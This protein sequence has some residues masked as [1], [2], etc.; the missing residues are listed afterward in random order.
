MSFVKQIVI[1]AVVIVLVVGGWYAYQ[2]RSALFGTPSTIAA[3]TP[4]S[5]PAAAK[6]GGP[7]G[8]SL[9]PVPV[10]AAPVDIATTSDQLSAIGTLAA[11]QEV[12]LF[13]Q[14][15]GIVT[16][17]TFKPGSH[18]TAGQTLVTLDAKDQQVAVDRA[19]VALDDAKTALDRAQRLSKTSNI[20]EVDLQTAQ[21]NER[22]AEIDARAAQ[23]DLDKL[24]IK[25][26]FDGTIGLT[27][28]SVGDLITSTTAIAT[29]DDM[30][31]LTL[32]FQSPERFAGRIAVG[33]ALKA[34]AE[35]LPGVNLAGKIV[36][37][38]SRIDAATRTLKLQAS[39]TNENGKLK[40]GMAISVVMDFPGQP[41]PLVPSLS[42]QYDRKG[43]FVWKVAGDVV[44][45]V[46][47][48][49][50]DRT[51]RAVSVMADLKKGDQVVTEGV[52]SLREGSKIARLDEAPAAATPAAPATP[53]PAAVA[54]AAASDAA[55]A[56]V[57]PAGA[58]AAPTRTD[59]PS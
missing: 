18:V 19:T 26:P 12:T 28:L 56:A 46:A 35:S 7:G 22:K 31:V 30:S 51:G 32:D 43:A 20:T 16:S 58:N 14:V 21:N 41:E 3:A 55:P 49:V 48:T 11:A 15:T 24:T 10:V 25:A 23:L 34:T 6:P 33:D 2:H 13:P 27:N 1:S 59:Q 45:R 44:N 42:I 47:V 54:P 57:K 50:L 4:G 53:A 38:D 52:Q 9:G 37:I 29:L 17:V 5:A 40:P 39:F 8:R 36:A